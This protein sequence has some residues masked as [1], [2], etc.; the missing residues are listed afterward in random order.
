MKWEMNTTG[1]PSV[2]CKGLLYP[3]SISKSSD[4]AD[5]FIDWLHFQSQLIV[6]VFKAADWLHFQSQ[7]M[8]W[9]YKFLNEMIAQINMI[10]KPERN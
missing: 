2:T 8:S 3:G 5:W 7:L 6:Y 10:F 1:H 9:R 4:C